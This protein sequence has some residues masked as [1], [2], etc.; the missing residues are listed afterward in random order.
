MIWAKVHQ[1]LEPWLQ[2]DRRV[3]LTASGVAGAV[4]LI[5]LL[6]FLQT[7]ELSALDQMF[8]LRPAEPIDDRIVIVGIDDPDINSLGT[9]PVPDTDLADLLDE[10]ESYHPRVVGLDIYRDLPVEPGSVQLR[11][12]FS[13]YENLI[14][15]EKLPD[16]YSIGVQPPEVLAERE[17]IGFNNVLIDPDGRVRRSILFWTIEG[18]AHTSF[19]LK[20]ALQYLEHEEIIP[21]AATRGNPAHLQLGSA[22]FRPLQPDD[23][24]YVRMDNGGYQISANFRSPVRSFPIVSMTD[25][26]EGNVAPEVMRDRIVLIGSTANSLQDFFYTPFTNSSKDLTAGVELHAHFVS[27][28]I[29]AA[30]DERS[31]IRVWPELLEWLWILGWSMAGGYLCWKVRSPGKVGLLLISAG[32]ALFLIGY[33]LFLSGWWIPVIPPAIAMVGS[34][35]GITSYIAHLEGELKKS[36]EFLNSVINTI[37]DPIFVKDKN[38]RWIVLNDSFSR[39]L[40]QPINE[41]L[42]KDE[43]AV[44]PAHQATVFRHQDDLAFNSSAEHESEGELT[45]TNGHT[46]LVSTKRSLHKDAA[47]NQFL[48]GIMHDITQRKRMED[49]LRRTAAE[50]VRS[51]AELRQRGDQLLQIAY[52]DPLTGLPNRQLFQERLIQAIE[53]AELNNHLIA[54]LFLDLDGFK[55]INDSEGHLVGDLLLKAVAQRLVNC[56]RATDMVAR[57]GGDEFVVILP[58]IPSEEDAGQVARKILATLSEIFVLQGKSI[59]VTTSVGISMYP[60]DGKSMEALIVESDQAMYRAK[61]LGKNRYEL[62]SQKK[63]SL[64]ASEAIAREGTSSLLET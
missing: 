30:L 14:G 58:A 57:L 60:A 1:R 21:Q 41:L 35:I 33:G 31:L 56:L 44:L 24:G 26:L 12:A 16:K 5:R 29:S 11:R 25:V 42:G 2:G 3:W 22:I 15:I 36:K 62:A 53:W 6:G 54:L 55:T 23:G 37:P 45:N 63:K 17:Q 61:E 46:Y 43:H 13:Q 28:I 39:F 10:I 47:G 19:A 32:A 51:N 48:V 34:A 59:S 52:H 18:E 50:L 38:H 8:R 9:W 27:Q 49:E 20:I 7:S 64:L 4:V 40:G